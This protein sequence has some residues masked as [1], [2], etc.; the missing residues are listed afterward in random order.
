MRKSLENIDL[1][2]GEAQV[3]MALAQ[4]LQQVEAEKQ[5]LRVQVKRLCQENGWLRD[6]LATTQ[7]KLQQSEQVR[8]Q[9]TILI[10]YD[11]KQLN[12]GSTLLYWVM[13]LLVL[14]LIDIRLC[15][16]L[17]MWQQLITGSY[18]STELWGCDIIVI[19]GGHRIHSD[20]FECLLSC[21]CV[22][23]TDKSV[24]DKD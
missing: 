9:A 4:H 21:C 8:S 23:Q 2:L 7:Q 15:T 10:Y 16:N 1:G 22:Q 12:T 3:M 13:A 17:N 19:N 24:I 14:F 18:W 5:K 6:E 11:V 20:H